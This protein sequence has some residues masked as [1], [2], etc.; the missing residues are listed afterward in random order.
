MTSRPGKLT[1]SLAAACALILPLTLILAHA[2]G[3]Q[4]HTPAA[5]IHGI[6]V[7][8]MDTSVS[9]GDDFYHYANGAWI[10]RTEIPPDRAGMGV[11][12]V[13]T[14]LT[15]KRTA[16]IIEEAAKSKSPANRQIADLYNSF[17]DEAGI[18]AK[19]LAPLKPHLDSIAAIHDKHEL[20]RALG[21]SLRADVDALNNT[22]FHTANLFGLW[23]APGFNDSAHYT[24][25]LLQGGIE[26][27]D[28]EYYLADSPHMRE[29]REKYLAHIAAMLKLTGFSG[30]EERAKRIF[31][32][33]HSIAEKHISLAENDDIHKANNTWKQA[34]FAAK[35]PGLDWTEY[36]RGAGLTHQA[37]FTVWQPT[38]FTAESA[39]VES[40]PLETWKDWLAFHLIEDF[41]GVLPKAIS[42][43]DFAFFGTT[44]TGVA[45]RR[46]RW[47]RGVTRVNDLLGDA[48]G[49]IYA[50]RY[51][52][53][54]AKAQAQD[55]VA[56][57][58]AAFRKRIDALDWMDPKTKAEAKAKLGTLYVGIG[59]PEHWHDYAGFEVKP[60]DIF[61]NMW[62]AGLFEYHRNVNRLGKP[63][64]RLE[65]S[66]SPQTVNAVNLPLQNALNFP[67]AI[68][69]PPFFDPKAPAAV[70]FG[71]I[72]AVIG[73]EISHTFD[74]EGSA[75]DA[76][77]R[78]RNWWTEADLEHFNKATAVLVA[79]YDTYKPFPDLS[80]NGKQTLAENIAD[81]A[82]IAAAYDGY[83]SSLAGKPAPEQ[84]GFSGDQQFFIAFAQDWGSKTR[85]AALRR[86][87]MT[88]GHSPGQY[89]ASTVRNID[90]WYAAFNVK[91]G[92]K[93]YLAPAERVRIW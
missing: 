45:Q 69:Q 66:M 12:T 42:D 56:K 23:V 80:L 28:R 24:A 3:A 82:G 48:V 68:L 18:E 76:Q 32:L 29:I 62:R 51:F 65:W 86:Q 92:Q 6:V 59:Y 85:E 91:P 74:S 16:A 11:F 13:L 35:A 50:Q 63:V 37:E 87:V 10:K 83:R 2:Y 21:E 44:L 26:L 46:P 52:P 88:D 40:V 47:Q 39:L 77:G 43:E 38:A 84:Q 4:A 15:E 33:E 89:R 67:A 71:A 27:P 57:I 55:M 20:A 1:L 90:A 30:P 54:Q 14:D 22:N 49:K 17:M 60:D 70:N 81:V 34:D 19:G 25:Y 7:A 61:G 41:G 53:P 58:I 5:D 73:H 78:V 36:F 64:D 8:N 79:Q 75:F 93:L 31:E 72:G 9:P